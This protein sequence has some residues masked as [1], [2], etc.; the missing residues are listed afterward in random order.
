MNTA[1]TEIAN[2]FL[3]ET[4]RKKKDYEYL[5]ELLVC[6]LF[7]PESLAIKLTTFRYGSE[8]PGRDS[9]RPEVDKD[10]EYADTKKRRCSISEPAAVLLSAVS[11]CLCVFIFICF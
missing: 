5:F 10:A 1:V 2:P 6:H 3:W 7:Y 11:L 4:T 8:E 9:W